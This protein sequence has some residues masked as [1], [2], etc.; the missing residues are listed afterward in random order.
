MLNGRGVASLEAQ[1]APEERLISRLT[2]QCPWGLDRE[3]LKDIRNALADG[4]NTNGVRIPAGRNKTK[5]SLQFVL[6]TSAMHKVSRLYLVDIL[7]AAGAYTNL[8]NAN[9]SYLSQLYDEQIGDALAYT[10]L[11]HR[12]NHTPCGKAMLDSVCNAVK[13]II[14][15]YTGSDNA[16]DKEAQKLAI[17]KLYLA[18]TYAE[19]EKRADVHYN[20]LGSEDVKRLQQKH[21]AI[22]GMK[23]EFL[24]QASSA[25]VPVAEQPVQTTC[26]AIYKPP[27]AESRNIGLG[28]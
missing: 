18:S 22:F 27:P 26:S 23:H 24:A 8:H 2:L 1:L 12:E 3:N 11:K 13:P 5:S 7:L 21:G 16:E 10:L 14:R 28:Q 6:E 17:Y 19:D 15:A 25:V 20:S 4:V 9:V